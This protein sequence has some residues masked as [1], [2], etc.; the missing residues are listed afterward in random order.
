MTF[1]LILSDSI[2][3][4][5]YTITTYGRVITCKKGGFVADLVSDV[6]PSFCPLNAL[7]GDF[8]RK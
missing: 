4:Q 8:Y 2:E 7:H 1:S 5:A 3:N 6:A